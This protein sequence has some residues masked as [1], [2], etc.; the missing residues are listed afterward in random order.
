MKFERISEA[1]RRIEEVRNSNAEFLNL[2]G[3]DLQEVPEAVFDLKNLVELNLSGNQI[4][5]IPDVV[6]SK[7]PKLRALGLYR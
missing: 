3:L 2:A 6:R 5:S 1:A 7:L 4:R